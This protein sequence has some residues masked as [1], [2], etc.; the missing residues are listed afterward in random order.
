M[1]TP[2]RLLVPVVFTFSM[3]ALAAPPAGERLSFVSCPIVRD[4]RSVPCW[5]SEYQGDTYYL[6][7]QSDVSAEVQP[8]LLGHQVL[9][10]G[11]VSEKPAICGGIVLEQV[12]LSVMPEL[13]ANCNT[14]LPAD[15]RY[16]IDFNPRPPGPSSGR[17]AFDPAP[18]APVTPPPPPTGEQRVPLYFDFDKGVS[19]RHPGALVNLL[20]LAAK[21][22]AT[23]L[24]VTGVRG[25]H[26]LSDGSLLQ[27]S[28]S[29]GQRRAEEVAKLLQ[30]AG[31]QLETQIDWIDGTSEADGIDDWQSRRVTVVLTQAPDPS[32]TGPEPAIAYSD[33]ALPTHTI[34]RPETLLGTYPVV[35][36]GNGSCINSSYGYREF[37]AQ[38]ASHGFIVVAVG[39]YRASP[40]PRAERPADPAAWPAF[41]TQSSQ[42]LDGLDWLGAE[43]ARAGSAWQ[44]YVDVE[45]VA[46][47]GHSCGGMQAMTVSTDPR[48][49]T[50]VILNSGIFPDGDQ[51]NARFGITRAQLQ[52]LHAP[53]AYFIGG[54]S[55]I[56]Y[57]NAEQDWQDLLQG[58]VP[59]LNANMDVGH[60]ATY[61]MPQ[62]GPFAAGPLAWL[63]WQLKEDAAA[64]AQLVGDQCGLCADG[65]WRLRQHGIE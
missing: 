9:V 43:Q 51:Y 58:Q 53:I 26:R 48:V 25:A 23:K 8:P 29:I 14:M 47:M 50:T 55:D 24:Q 33:P 61:A 31:L 60:G 44:G 54:E 30:G 11:I 4:T 10:E 57:V 1:L 12:R 65:A 39:P 17:L 38:V 13:D 41:E 46:V 6:T 21:V 15:A 18:G 5:I 28:A 56:A 19:F 22:Q 34:Y 42:L 20:D 49:T 35:L 52:T 3:S 64:K 37:L 40:P 32:G 16:Q 2:T 36:W 62:G 27:E 59:A 7:I 45:H 63:Q